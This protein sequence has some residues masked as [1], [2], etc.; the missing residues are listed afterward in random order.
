MF[1]IVVNYVGAPYFVDLARSVIPSSDAGDARAP[2]G[3]DAQL[4]HMKTHSFE[5]LRQPG[6]PE[7][8][9]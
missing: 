3:A 5:P 7:C 4:G 2:Y 1:F 9:C 8:M 6:G